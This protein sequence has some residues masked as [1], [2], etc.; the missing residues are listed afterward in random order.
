MSISAIESTVR[1]AGL[2]PHRARSLGLRVVAEGVESPDMR[3]RLT[4][5]GCDHAQGYSFSRAL[6]QAD[7]AAWLTARELSELALSA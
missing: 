6:P 2:R 1:V 7:F 5:M 4:T 3:A